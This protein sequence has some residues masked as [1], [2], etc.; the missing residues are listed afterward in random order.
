MK[1]SSSKDKIDTKEL[2]NMLQ[3]M[4]MLTKTTADFVEIMDKID[5]TYKEKISKPTKKER[6]VT[7]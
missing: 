1:K 5:V 4:E 2:K 6:G 7:K 3:I